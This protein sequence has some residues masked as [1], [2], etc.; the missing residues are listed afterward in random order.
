MKNDDLISR[1]EMVADLECF[2]ASMADVVFRLIM[3]RVIDRVK[4]L[5]AAGEPVTK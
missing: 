3:D 4:A 5:P 1:A 2:K